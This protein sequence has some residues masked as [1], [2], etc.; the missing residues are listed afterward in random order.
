MITADILLWINFLVLL[1]YVPVVCYLDIK[2]R[3]V[4]PYLWIPMVI[5]CTP[6]ISY[7]LASGYYPWYTLMISF[8]MIVVFKAAMM[9]H[10]I[11]GADFLYLSL[12]SLYWVVTPVGWVHGLMQ[13]Q[14]YI[15]LLFVSFITATVILA[16]NYLSDNRWD[17]AMMMSEYKNGIPYMVPISA[18]FLLSVVFG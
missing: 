9:K 18:A 11:E 13:V 12:I 6:I 10:Y 1:A 17:I 14:F 16:Y 8:V 4:H 7:M 2:Y 5:V 3:E 15:Y